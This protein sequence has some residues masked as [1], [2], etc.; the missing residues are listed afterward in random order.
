MHATAPQQVPGDPYSPP[1]YAFSGDN[2]GAT[3]QGV[4]ADEITVT[5]RAARGPLGGGDLRRHLRPDRQ[6]LARVGQ[7]HARGAGRVLLRHASSSTAGSIKLAVLQGRGQRRQRAARRRQGEGAGRRRAGGE[8]DRRLRRHQRHHDPLRRRAGPQGVVNI[9]SPYPSRQWFESRRP[10]SWSLF[11][12]GT[13]VVSSSS[14]S[15]IGRFPAGSNGAVRRRRPQRQAP[16]VRRGRPGER[17]VPGVGQL[18]HRQARR[19]RHRGRAE[20]EV[21]ARHR[22][23]AEPGVEHHR[24]AQGRRGHLDPVR[25]RPG[26][27]RARPHAEGQRAGLRA[28]VADLRAGV[29]RPGHR[30]PAHRH[31]G[32]GRTPSGSPTTPSPSRRAARSRTPPTSRCGPAT[33]PPSASRRSTTR[34]TCWRSAS[35]WRARTSR[36]RRSRRACSP[37]RAA[38]GPR[39][40]WGFGPGDYTPTDDFRE[41]WWDADRISPPEQPGRR[42]GAARRRPALHPGPT[43]PTGPAGYFKEG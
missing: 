1:C 19:R 42:V 22:V 43:R 4:T 40:L 31:S 21:Q 25:L 18:L 41:I 16:Q 30:V 15:V 34:C 7:G 20:H 6:R 24:P 13:N 28:R 23:D 3:Y 35:R 11:P 8:G 33:S 2:G 14:A 39:G 10:Y 38:S 37:T 29:R 17:R 36:R 12:D 5:V 9:G 27:A 32:S 26:D